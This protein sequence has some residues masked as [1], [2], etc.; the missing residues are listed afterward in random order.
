MGI[1]SLL[2]AAFRDGWQ[3]A[4]RPEQGMKEELDPPGQALDYTPG[5]R[6]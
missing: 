4:R 2:A 6:P 5:Q 1:I 3:R